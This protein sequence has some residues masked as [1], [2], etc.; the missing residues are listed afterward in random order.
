VALRRNLKLAP[1]FFGPFQIIQKVGS[2]AY[3]LALPPESK[4]HPVFHV[5][6]LKKK[7]GQQVLPFPTMPP[8][9]RNGELK[10][11]PEAILERRMQKIGTRPAT[12]VLV[13]WCGAPKEDNT[14]ELL[15]KLRDT[16]PHLVGKVF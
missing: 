11:E 6:C 10:P 14:W 9:D 3:K 12:E 4:I 7:L 1:R 15:Y 2:V 8:V 5:S 16:Y 13:Q